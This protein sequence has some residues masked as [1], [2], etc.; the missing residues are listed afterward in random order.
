MHLL[1][2]PFVT[3]AFCSLP[4]IP[5]DTPPETAG[6]VKVFILAG[7]SNMEGKGFPEPLA[8][9]VSQA[10]YRDRYQH[11][12]KDGDF[13]DFTR[14]LRVALEADPR[15]PA[16]DWSVRKDVWVNF[17]KQR[18]DLT[19]GYGVPS[20]AFGP[21]YNFG[22]V[23]GDHFDEQVLIIKT[24]WGGK[25]LGRDFLSPS[26][27]LPSDDE[28]A[29]MAQDRNEQT[30][31]N[32]ERNRKK[33]EEQNKDRPFTPRPLVTAAELK[34][35]Y[36]HYYREMLA[37]VRQ[38]LAELG[39]RFP[40][41][42]GQGYELAGFVWFQGWNDQFT[43]EWASRYG[44]YLANFILDVRKDLEA[45]DLPFV[46]GQV[47]FDGQRQPAR[48]K[49][50]EDNARVKIKKGQLAM[51]SHPKLSGKVRVVKTDRFWDMDADAIYRGKGG[52][53]AD[54]EKW[55]RFGNDRPYHYYGSPWFFAQIGTAFGKAMLEML[56]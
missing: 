36:G 45:P 29:E 15:K 49:D 42:Q 14:K 32:N 11:F 8:Y 16:Y 50:G 21:E 20:K 24:A 23:V 43:N 27:P 9:Q 28:F 19:V 54:V 46:I 7:Q 26:S 44:E 17:L 25:S 13:G 30:K 37:E 5:P 34:Q 31:K 41:Y 10:E 40:G 3:V 33:H 48:S 1:S 22:H 53:S 18:G 6:K 35:P 55:R 38:T 12:I 52:W 56:D 2:L 4:S 47:G 39:Q 51:A